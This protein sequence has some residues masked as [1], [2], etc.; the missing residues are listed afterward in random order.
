MFFVKPRKKLDPAAL[1]ALFEEQVRKLIEKGYPAL[2][3]L[4]EADFRAKLESLWQDKKGEIEPLHFSQDSEIPFLLVIKT[5]DL[6][7]RLELVGKTELD[8]GQI[9]D[10]EETAR[11]DFYFLLDVEDGRG[12]VAKSPAESLKRFAKSGRHALTLDESLALITH[13]PEILNDHYLIS[14]GTFIVKGGEDL[15]LL[16]LLDDKPELHYAWFGIA[17]GH[18][19]SA[20]CSARV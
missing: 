15:P 18:Y 11:S 12:E 10:K 2:L 1:H 13:H 8:L 6:A 16:W 5:G 20:S 17:H 4:S 14:A 19:G 9:K 7:K 3:S